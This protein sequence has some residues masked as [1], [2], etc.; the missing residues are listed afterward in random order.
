MSIEQAES[1]QM[2]AAAA[3]E[4]AMPPPARSLIRQAYHDTLASVL[5]RIG[6]AWLFMLAF[7]AVFAPFLADSHPYVMKVNG[8]WSSPALI[9]LTPAD[10]LLL[11][12]T[13][14]VVVLAIWRRL[15]FLRSLGLIAA[16]VVVGQK[17]RKDREKR[18]HEKPCKPDA[19]QDAGQGIVICLA[20]E[21]ARRGRHRGLGRGRRKHLRGFGLFNRHSSPAGRPPHTSGRKSDSRKAAAG[22][23]SRSPPSALRDRAKTPHRP[24][25][26]PSRESQRWIRSQPTRQ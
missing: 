20:N 10:V 6:L 24:S 19:R 26:F 15:S 1:S 18:Q 21:A 2:L 14:T 12:A 23:R 17:G 3:A 7:F 22:W 11:I 8:R 13:A 4:P 16:V 9:H 25:A 5:A